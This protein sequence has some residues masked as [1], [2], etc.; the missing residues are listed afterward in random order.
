MLHITVAAV[1][2]TIASGQ[3][4][5]IGTDCEC[6]VSVVATSPTYD[7]GSSKGDEGCTRESTDP[8][9]VWNHIGVEFQ[10]VGTGTETFDY[11]I[12]CVKPCKIT[13]VDVEGEAF[14]GHD[15]K[16]QLWNGDRT[17]MFAE[18]DADLG[19][20]SYHEVHVTADPDYAY[21]YRVVEVDD[22]CDTYR[23]RSTL[24]I[25]AEVDPSYHCDA[26]PIDDFLTKCSNEHAQ[27]G[28]DILALQSAANVTG[29]A[30]QD[31]LADIRLLQ[32][33][34]TAQQTTFDARLQALEDW[35]ATILTISDAHGEPIVA[36]LGGDFGVEN[37]SPFVVT[38]NAKDLLI[39]FLAVINVALMVGVCVACTRAKG[40]VDCTDTK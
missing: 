14:C 11:R 9:D 28:S 26:F 13:R 19:S 21:S 40:V 15:T 17:T 5:D 27:T 3:S 20:N 16:L 38:M 10:G 8:L 18:K 22:T 1:L 31:L 34:S 2:A 37:P 24:N 32:A 25:T 7:L 33:N 30:I 39:L 6:S 12:D 23:C 36:D 4:V 29:Q 35:K